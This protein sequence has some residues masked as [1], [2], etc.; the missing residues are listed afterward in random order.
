MENIKKI[1]EML[2]P[3]I[4]DVFEKMFFVFAEPLREVEQPHQLRAAIHFE[5]PFK[6]EMQ[7][8][9]SSELAKTMAKNMLNLE[10]AEV[11]DSIMA[12][13]VKE[14]INMICGSFLR[15]VDPVHG[16]QMSIPTC[17]RL[18][19]HT[20]D[21]K[22]GDGKGVRLAFATECGPFEVMVATEK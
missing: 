6:G 13:C 16:S 19:N 10:D 3:S 7:L 12:D 18:S 22:G 17:D 14:A 4:F 1:G 21:G 9:L 20:D 8:L 2:L 5:G 15:K 11:N